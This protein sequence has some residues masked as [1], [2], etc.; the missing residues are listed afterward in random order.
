ML[1]HPDLIGEILS[2]MVA[3]VTIPVTVKIRAGWDEHS[4]CAPLVTQIAERAG[5]TA[6][7]IHGR[8]REQ[9]YKGPANWD[10]I[11]ACKAAAK[12]M[13]VI[14]NGDLF[15][16][17]SVI[18]MRAHTDCDAWLVSRGTLGQPWIVEDA[19]RVL[20]GH[21]PLLRTPLD[22]SHVL[23]EHFDRICAYHGERQALLDFRRVG[24][25]YLKRC[26]GV[27]E[28]R[29]QLNQSTSTAQSLS[30]IEQFPWQ[31][32]VWAEAFALVD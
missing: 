4:I 11:K 10:Y 27:K 23:L 31:E 20:A 14:G 7:A 6:I 2:A 29:M 17:Q 25:W 15:D 16:A 22:V 32:V 30:L 1:K 13:L 12:D 3:A 9:G 8:T 24:C 19:L 28:L 26:V 21:K 18:R 5:A